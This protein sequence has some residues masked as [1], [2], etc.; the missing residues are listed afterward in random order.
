MTASCA[1]LYRLLKNDDSVYY[2][3]YTHIN[4]QKNLPYRLIVLNI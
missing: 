4:H 1:L 2:F 3:L